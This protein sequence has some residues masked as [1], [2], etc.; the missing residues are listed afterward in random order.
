MIDRIVKAAYSKA[1]LYHVRMG[2][3]KDMDDLGSLRLGKLLHLL[4]VILRIIGMRLRHNARTL[5]YPPSGPDKFPVYRDMVILCTTRWLFNKTI[6]HFHAGGISELYPNLNPVAKFFYR[7]AFFHPDQAIVLAKTVPPDAQFLQA[8]KTVVLP[9]GID[10]RFDEKLRT[11]TKDDM[12]HLLFVAVL[13][14]SKG[15]F[16]MLEACR[17]LKERGFSFVLDVVGMFP[18][19]ETKVSCMNFVQQQGLEKYVVFHGVLLGQAKDEAYANADIFC[20]PSFFESETFGLVVVEAMQFK[21]PV[22]A[23]RWRGIPGSV[24]EEGSGILIPTQD[25]QALSDAVARLINDAS[26]R[27]RMGERGRA[28]YLE[29]FTSKRFFANL[30]ECFA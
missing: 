12:L 15:I 11:K 19:E 4:V 1:E 21:L 9:Y 3:A 28:I 8:K 7:R 18:D 23:T 14:K 26:L 24:E 10:D 13:Y 17:Q 25:A 27:K 22:V 16:I 30:D 29:K 6:F 20:F 5:Y 2:F